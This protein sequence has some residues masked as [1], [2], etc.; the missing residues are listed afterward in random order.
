MSS[1]VRGKSSVALQPLGGVR[2]RA[3]A[4]REKVETRVFVARREMGVWFNE[5]A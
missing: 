5:H 2:A 3:I 1:P 4:A